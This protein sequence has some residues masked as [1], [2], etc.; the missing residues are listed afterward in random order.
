V[1]LMFL[2]PAVQTL[3][4]GTAPIVDP[5]LPPD[6]PITPFDSPQAQ[7][8]ETLALAASARPVDRL[9]DEGQ[10]AYRNGR[11]LDAYRLL[12]GAL[13]RDEK[14]DQARRMLLRVMGERD[15]RLR[16]LQ[17]AASRADEELEFEE[18]A[19]QWDAV[20][21]LTLEAEPLHTRARAEAARLRQRASQ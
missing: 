11:L 4:G 21:A 16:S 6:T 19:K 15:L 14:H 9:F 7:A 5:S 2:R 10:L 13:L 18:A 17:S 1:Y 3:G 8:I 20:Q 12:H